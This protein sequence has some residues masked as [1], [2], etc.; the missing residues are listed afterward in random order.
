MH[1]LEDQKIGY[2]GSKLWDKVRANL[3]WFRQE[4]PDA[5]HGIAR[6]TATQCAMVL[7]APLCYNAFINKK[8]KYEKR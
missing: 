6:L 1:T 4:N 5:I 2:G 3:N 8:E 7:T